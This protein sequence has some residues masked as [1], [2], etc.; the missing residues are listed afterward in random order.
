MCEWYKSND[1]E[2]FHTLLLCVCVVL[3]ARTHG[4][5][6]LSFSGSLILFSFGFFLGVSFST[7]VVF[8]AK[9]KFNLV[10]NCEQY[11]ALSFP[12]HTHTCTR[13]SF[14]HLRNCFSIF[15][16]WLSN[17][18]RIE[19]NC[20]KMWLP[21]K[22]ENKPHKVTYTHTSCLYLNVVNKT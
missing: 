7:W 2:H 21:Q 3:Y 17:E 1:V 9:V 4:S 12:P 16:L 5:L 8:V 6:S 15:L 19:K 10:F 20:T 22:M 11:Q 14:V 13:H 18:T